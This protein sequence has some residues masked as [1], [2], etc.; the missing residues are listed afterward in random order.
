MIITVTDEFNKDNDFQCPFSGIISTDEIP[1]CIV[2]K[3]P[4]D[5]CWGSP[6]IH[7]NCPLLKEDITIHYESEK[8]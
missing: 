3:S 7:R 1:R 8:K 4:I 5:A 2:P 6:A